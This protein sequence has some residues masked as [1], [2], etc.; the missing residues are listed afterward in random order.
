M[1]FIEVAQSIFLHSPRFYWVIITI[2]YQ[3]IP[4]LWHQKSAQ[5]LGN[6]ISFSWGAGLAQWWE[7]SPSTNVSRVRFP[8]PA[9][10]VDSVC[11]F[12]TLLREV[13]LRV[14]R[15]SPLLK[16]Q[17]LIWLIWLIWFDLFNWFTVSPISRALVLGC[18]YYYYYTIG[19]H[20]T[21]M[22]CEKHP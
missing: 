17:Q 13:F 3:L 8:D 9:S 10:Y 12:S 5:S 18:Y 4:Q 11:W 6:T 21:S 22:T 14:L 1:K 20:S 7:R 2:F 19:Y 16:N 15:F